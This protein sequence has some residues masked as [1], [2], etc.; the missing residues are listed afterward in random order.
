MIGN[1][2]RKA[3]LGC[4]SSGSGMPVSGHDLS[5]QLGVSRQVVVQDVALL[6]EA[7][8]PIMATSR[9]Y[10]LASWRGATRPSRTL[11]VRHTTEQ[12]EDELQTIVDL[13]GRVTDVSVNHRVYGH[14]S[15]N[16]SVANR[17]DVQCFVDDIASGV[18]TPLMT[19]TAGYHFHHLE[20]DTTE[21]LDEI[22]HALAAKGYLAEVL[23]YEREDLAEG[24]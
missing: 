6:R 17:R 22:E 13:G 1:E 3:L 21:Q 2:R 24:T 10:V 16:L 20:A 14:I 9:G 11:K 19:V 5:S 4:L 15:V 7:G 23:P 8:Y 18:S 12:T